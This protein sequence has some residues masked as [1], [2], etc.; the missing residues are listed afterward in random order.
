[1]NSC[2]FFFQ[3]IVS[4]EKSKK[5]VENLYHGEKQI[6]KELHKELLYYKN[7]MEEA[8]AAKKEAAKAMNKLKG[9]Q[10]VQTIINGLYIVLT[11]SFN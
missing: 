2:L 11:H 6:V 4:L 10:S 5:E 1:M 3:R 8:Q 7:Q 9:L